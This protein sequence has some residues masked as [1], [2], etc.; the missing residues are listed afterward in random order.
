M[1][2]ETFVINATDVHVFA[3]ILP[4]LFMIVFIL[5]NCKKF[6]LVFDNV[7]GIVEVINSRDI[8]IQVKIC[9][10]NKERKR[11]DRKNKPDMW[12]QEIIRNSRAHDE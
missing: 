11:T 8:Q 7:V 6:G 4:F 12:L 1:R 10:R 9:L 2:L 3:F 5:D